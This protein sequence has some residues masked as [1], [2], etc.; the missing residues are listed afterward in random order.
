MARVQYKFALRRLAEAFPELELPAKL[1]EGLRASEVPTRPCPCG[2][3]QLAQWPWML[4]TASL[5]FC[6]GAVAE[7]ESGY[8]HICGRHI[9]E[10]MCWRNEW[11]E[12]WP[13]GKW[14][15]C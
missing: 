5:G 4:Q 14:L 13:G 7:T 15:D 10:K 11:V 6:P 9:W 8:K 3:G 12:A 1:H 2:A